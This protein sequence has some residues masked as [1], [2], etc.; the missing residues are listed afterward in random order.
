[1]FTITLGRRDAKGRFRFSQLNLEDGITWEQMLEDLNLSSEESGEVYYCASGDSHTSRN[2]A[3]GDESPGFGTVYTFVP[4]GV[5]MA[6]PAQG[7]TL[8]LNPPDNGDPLVVQPHP[9]GRF[10]ARA[11]DK[12]VSGVNVIGAPGRVGSYF[13]SLQDVVLVGTTLAEWALQPGAFAGGTV[14][15]ENPG[16]TAIDLAEVAIAANKVGAGWAEW[17]VSAT[18]GTDFFVASYVGHFVATN[19][20]GTIVSAV[21]SHAALDLEAAS[22]GATPITAPASLSNGANKVTFR[23]TPSAATPALTSITVAF[24]IYDRL[25]NT[26]TP[27]SHG[28]VFEE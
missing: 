17:V 3:T 24:R 2:P 1:M 8:L 25:G 19:K 23:V 12:V 10:D 9:G 6:D 16:T 15:I 27:I 7:A 18:D 22:G 20:A 4:T 5:A 26:V 13:L 11:I 14:T 21:K 28:E